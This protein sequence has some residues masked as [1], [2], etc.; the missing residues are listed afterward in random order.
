LLFYEKP[1]T[2]RLFL[3]YNRDIGGFK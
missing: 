1:R 3:F 2:A